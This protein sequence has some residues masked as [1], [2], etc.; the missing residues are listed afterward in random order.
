MK[1]LLLSILIFIIAFMGT[2][3]I[4]CYLPGMRIKLF[5]PPGEYFIESIMHTVLLKSIISSLVGLI[6]VSI[7]LITKRRNY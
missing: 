6:A 4:I 1:K 2:Y 7:Y 3:I 5:A